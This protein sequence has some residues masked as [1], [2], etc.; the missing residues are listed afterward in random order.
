M[1]HANRAAM[2]RHMLVQIFAFLAVKLEGTQNITPSLTNTVNE[3][4]DELLVLLEE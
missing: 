2:K 1:V 3:G 4:I